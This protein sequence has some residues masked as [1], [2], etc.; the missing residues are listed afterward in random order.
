MHKGITSFAVVAL[1]LAVVSTTFQPL[2]AQPAA[3]AQGG[4]Q[5]S[6]QTGN[7]ACGKLLTYRQTRGGLAQ[8]GYSMS[9][10][11]IEVSAAYEKEA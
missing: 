9:N 3:L 5:S 6:P 1:V 2:T 7:T 4:C 11:L 10:E 8:Q